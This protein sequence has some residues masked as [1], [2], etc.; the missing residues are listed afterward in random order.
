MLAGLLGLLSSI[1]GNEK[2]VGMATLPLLALML[3][4]PP[5]RWLGSRRARSGTRY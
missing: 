3:V 5:F 2:G 1:A 4:M